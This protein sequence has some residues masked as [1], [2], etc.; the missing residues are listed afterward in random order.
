[1]TLVILMIV[2]M[3]IWNHTEEA[4][5]SSVKASW[6]EQKAGIRYRNNKGVFSKSKWEKI[7]GKWFYFNN[8]GIV[9]TGWRTLKGKTYYLKKTG[10]AGNKGRMLT[11]WR[12]IGKQSHYFNS[13]GEMQ[14]GWVKIKNR[15]YYFSPKGKAGVKGRM[16][17]GWQTIS[18]KTYFLKRSGKHGN[19]GRML[20][21][22]HTIEGKKHK[23]SSSGEYMP[24]LAQ[25]VANTKAAKK[26]NQIITVANG[27]LTLWE[28]S[29]SD[30]KSILSVACKTGRD[31]IDKNMGEGDHK[32]PAGAYTMT[33]SFGKGNNPG[34]ILPY[35][36]I[37]K[38]S[39]WIS[40]VKDKD[41]NTWQERKTSSPLDEHLSKYSTYKYV[42]VI[43]HNTKRVPGKGS[44]IFLHCSNGTPT[45]GCVAVP[46][47]TMLRL[48]KRVE[49]GAYI[50]I[51]K[52]AAEISKY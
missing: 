37:T 48:M 45:A 5:A 25:R 6:V 38:N 9:A 51:G 7:N 40:N 26:T 27:K 12:T 22:T 30:W 28:K 52:T 14:T 44:A 19:K 15:W 39:Y 20:T 23:F 35:R 21:G 11:G 49:K 10:K 16:L 42:I 33:Q 18:G 3:L 29:G 24:S 17:T 1:M 2:P 46:E 47:K 13:S 36:K 50:I 41:Y 4:L 32:T 43:D 31:G 8:K 34:T